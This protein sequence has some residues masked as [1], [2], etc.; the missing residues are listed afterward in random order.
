MTDSIVGE[1]EIAAR[2]RV[3]DAT[4]HQWRSRGLLPDQ[5]GYVSGAPAWRWSTIER[6]AWSTGR[7]PHLRDHILALLNESPTGG[8]FATPITGQLVRLGVV[9]EGTSAARI[10][11]VLTDLFNEGLVSLHLRNEWRI[12]DKGR[13]QVGT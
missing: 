13:Q 12:T 11:S 8:G 3:R 6:W 7:M 1:K 2:L 4:V 5:E 9:G 10:A